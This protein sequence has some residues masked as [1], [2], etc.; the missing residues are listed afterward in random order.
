M[1]LKGWLFFSSI[2]NTVTRDLTGHICEERDFCLN[3]LFFLTLYNFNL[4][5]DLTF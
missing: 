4:I 2:I 1:R 5:C 3:N